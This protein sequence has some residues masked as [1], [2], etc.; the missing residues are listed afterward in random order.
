MTTTSTVI[1][2]EKL[3]PLIVG[4]DA[5]RYCETVAP[6]CYI[7]SDAD[8][9]EAATAA[10]IVAGV[11][12]WAT[13]VL[14]DMSSRKLT[15][16]TARAVL[17]SRYDDAIE[18]AGSVDRKISES[19]WNRVIFLAARA[20]FVATLHRPSSSADDEATAAV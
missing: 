20:G 17:D 3:I 8:G 9:S 6:G 2:A 16:A 18:V 19:I 13:E 7:L 4:V 11:F 12:T 10:S 5:G 14:D 1:L 15:V